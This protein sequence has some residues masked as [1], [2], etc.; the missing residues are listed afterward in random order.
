VAER[1]RR[2]SSEWI[3]A[4]KTAPRPKPATEPPPIARPPSESGDGASSDK[5]VADMLEVSQTE[6]QDAPPQGFET[7]TSKSPSPF[8]GSATVPDI[9]LSPFAEETAMT[10]KDAPRP[11]TGAALPLGKT[12]TP[13]S[14]ILP[15]ALAGLRKPS[16]KTAPPPLPPREARP[17]PANL[18]RS[19]Q[20]VL[21]SLGPSSD[22]IAATPP[23]PPQTVAQ[24]P[25]PS[26]APVYPQVAPSAGIDAAMASLLADTGAQF[27]VAQGAAVKAQWKTPHR[28]AMHWAD[29]R[30]G[31]LAG[32]IRRRP[33]KIGIALGL[34]LLGATAWIGVSYL[35][36]HKPLSAR[37]LADLAK[38][39]GADASLWRFGPLAYMY[40]KY[41]TLGLVLIGV[42][43]MFRGILFVPRR[44][45]FCRMCNAPVAADVKSFSYECVNGPHRVRRRYMPMFLL[46]CAFWCSAGLL[47]TIV[48]SILKHTA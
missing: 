1:Q 47:A 23:A 33:R 20:A 3:E 44:K 36:S 10:D 28:S 34:L 46:F 39:A 4:L 21:T 7:Q 42:I 35:P 5:T 13:D 43:V 40:A 2:T 11:D 26:I 32:Q 12:L 25:Q 14:V 22:V 31:A 9:A 30:K 41:A 16:G 17:T 38:Q 29:L 45:L 6:V 27:D 15:P 18:P 8:E 37:A 24:L 19:A 48:W